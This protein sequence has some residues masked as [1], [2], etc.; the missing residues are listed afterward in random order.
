MSYSDHLDTG[1]DF[2]IDDVVGEIPAEY[3][4]PRAC[5]KVGP[6]RRR[7]C[8]QRDRAVDFL[9]KRLGHLEA[10]SK[11]PV[12]GVIDFPESFRGELNLGAAH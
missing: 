11:V 1:R 12:K 3:I 8:D 2:S 7:D 6:D 5:L 9:N 10:S 4:P